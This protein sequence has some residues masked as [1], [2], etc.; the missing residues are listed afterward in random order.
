MT[1]NRCDSADG[2][3]RPTASARWH[4]DGPDDAGHTN[5]ERLEGIDEFSAKRSPRR[6]SG[7]V[8]EGPQGAACGG[9]GCF[10]QG[11]PCRPLRRRPRAGRSV[12][13]L[14]RIACRRH[15][16]AEIGAALY[17]SRKTAN[18]HV[19]AIMAKL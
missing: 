11:R 10:R 15:S 17:I 14:V 5:I 7:R 12:M 1:P 2:L 8:A 3:S 6:V 16:D 9:E 4:W 18:R 13:R 19:G